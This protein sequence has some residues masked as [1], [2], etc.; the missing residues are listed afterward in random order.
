MPRSAE[1][2]RFETTRAR[3]PENH[4]PASGLPS[5]PLSVIRR[6]A[7]EVDRLRA[8]LANSH[9]R[10]RELESAAETDPL[11]GVLNRRGFERE[12]HRALHHIARY[13]G[14]LALI[15]LDLDGFKPI[16]DTYGHTTG[17]RVLIEV[18]DILTAGVRTSDSVA[19]LGGDEFAVLLWNINTL[20]ATVK[21]ISLEESIAGLSLPG[22]AVGASAGVALARPDDTI[23]TLVARA[24]AAMYARKADRRS[25]FRR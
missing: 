23:A 22:I 2:L 15:Y 21:S 6:L 19:R 11:C 9:D 4:D 17:D 12:I 24:D 5:H 13:G 8:D 20:Q 18:S 7:A 16:N 3:S 25:A 1:I 10:I 14:A